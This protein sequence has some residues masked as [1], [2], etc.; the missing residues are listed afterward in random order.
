V[1]H[2]DDRYAVRAPGIVQQ[3]VQFLGPRAVK[4]S[5]RFVRKQHLRL[6]DQRPRNGHA[7][8]FP[9]RERVGTVG[10]SVRDVQLL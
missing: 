10:A 4:V 3:S 9:A 5:G 8:L 2:Y 6:V 7:L 1:R